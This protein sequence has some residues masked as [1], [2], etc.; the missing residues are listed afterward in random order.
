MEQ[1]GRASA[2][3]ELAKQVAVTRTWG[4]AFGHSLVALGQAEAMVDPV[5]KRWD[6]SAMQLIVEEAGGRMTAF[7]GS[8]NPQD[9]AVSTNGLLHEKILSAFSS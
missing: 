2:F 8:G 3:L 1:H 6:I 5:V 7:D 4:D 9:Q